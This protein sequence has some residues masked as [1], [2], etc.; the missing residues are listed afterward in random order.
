[1]LGKAGY[2]LA[3][4]DPRGAEE[5]IRKLISAGFLLGDEGVTLIDNLIGFVLVRT[6]GVALESFY[7]AT[8]QTEEA[9]ALTWVRET[10]DRSADL[11]SVDEGWTD[12]EAALAQMP[13]TVR[14]PDAVRGLRWE[15]FILLNGLTPCLN[16]NRVVFG[17]EEGFSEFLAEA[18]EALVRY[19]SEEAFFE[20][21]RQ[22]W[23]GQISGSGPER[24]IGRVVGLTLGGG[25][26]PGSCAAFLGSIRW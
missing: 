12:V 18:R 26:T 19:P 23:F 17:P 9:E 6:G 16:A 11:A 22:G 4:G 7:R 25:G 10:A 1:M 5:S 20:L 21:A 15:Y 3:N 8:G 24:L 14:S 13:Q 2:E